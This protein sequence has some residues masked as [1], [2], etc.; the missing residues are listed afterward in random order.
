MKRL[1]VVLA[2]AVLDLPFD[3]LEHASKTDAGK[4]SL[5]AGGPVVVYHKEIKPAG[6]A[7]ADQDRHRQAEGAWRAGDF[8]QSVP[9]RLFGGGG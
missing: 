4:F 6:A 8:G 7:A 3:E 9:H 1:S 2:L 5:T